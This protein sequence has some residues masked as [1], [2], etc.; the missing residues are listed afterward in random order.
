[1]HVETKTLVSVFLTTALMLTVE[2]VILAVF[3]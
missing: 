1:M 3:A 2:V